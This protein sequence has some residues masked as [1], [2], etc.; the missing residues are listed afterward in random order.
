[1]SSQ[2][3]QERKYLR[4]KHFDYSLSGAYFVTICT[5]NRNAYF[6]KYPHLQKIAHRFWNDLEVKFP[7]VK[8]DEFVIMPNHVHGIIFIMVENEVR[9]ARAIY[10]SSRYL[11]TLKKRR[12]ML[13][14]K[15]VGY[16]K[17]NTAKH[18]NQIM[19]RSGQPFWQRN[20][21]EHVVRNDAEL[22]RIRTYIQN[23]PLKWELDRDNPKSRNYN[24]DHDS[25]WKEVYSRG[26]S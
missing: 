1:M 9:D 7:M 14:P 10:E 26:N 25:Y 5:N 21:Y 22:L 15:V 16:F 11:P 8:L 18:I 4:L 6:E 19:N 20:Y 24:L 3:F 23:N 12:N 2:P 17:M 13:L